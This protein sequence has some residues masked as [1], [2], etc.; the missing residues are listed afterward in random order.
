MD[1]ESKRI[2]KALLVKELAALCKLG[3]TFRT[4]ELMHE[5]APTIVD[6][7]IIGGPGWPT[8]PE[9][10][11]TRY[12]RFR[13]VIREVIEDDLP[14]IEGIDQRDADGAIR[15]FRLD[16]TSPGEYPLGPIQEE[17]S[18]ELFF[19]KGAAH[20]RKF[21]MEP[22]LEA[23]ADGL[24]AREEDANKPPKK[25]SSNSS[26]RQGSRQ[27]KRKRSTGQASGR[28]PPSKRTRNGARDSKAA[29]AGSQQSAQRGRQRLTQ[30]PRRTASPTRK[31]PARK[32][33]PPRRTEVQSASP[34]PTPRLEPPEGTPARRV[35][36]VAFVVLL[37]VLGLGLAAKEFF[38][39]DGNSLPST[40]YTVVPQKI[41]GKDSVSPK[42]LKVIICAT[43]G[44]G[45]SGHCSQSSPDARSFSFLRLHHEDLGGGADYWD[46][47]F[48]AAGNNQLKFLYRKNPS[49][50]SHWGLVYGETDENVEFSDNFVAGLSDFGD[51]DLAK[52]I[53]E[54]EADDEGLKWAKQGGIA[55]SATHSDFLDRSDSGDNYDSDDPF[56][57]AI[58]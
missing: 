25:Q 36:R 16:K 13:S 56:L 48:V 7:T 32:K 35:G 33:L 41:A 17:V 26:K 27:P 47:S 24:I 4:A 38:H 8:D 11:R 37:T 55:T 9:D 43:T 58:E 50:S 40:Q 54:P 5:K 51:T 18:R 31:A 3:H 29:K 52:N 2:L 21:R 22:V 57:K 6:L 20:F 19:G 39:V 46:Y 1:V 53:L 12:D 30:S 49:Q 42:Q 28:K 15:V 44:A 10:Q 14:K 45:G 34:P 23:I